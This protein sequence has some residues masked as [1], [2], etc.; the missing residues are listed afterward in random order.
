MVCATTEHSSQHKKWMLSDRRDAGNGCRNT[1][2]LL[3]NVK[4]KFR[5]S[6]Q[7]SGKIYTSRTHLSLPNFYG[8]WHS[9]NYLILH[10]LCSLRSA[11]P[12][13]ACNYGPARLISPHPFKRLLCRLSCRKILINFPLQHAVQQDLAYTS[14]NQYYCRTRVH[15]LTQMSFRQMTHIAVQQ[16]RTAFAAFAVQHNSCCTA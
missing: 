3:Q 1:L 8:L 7:E 11:N 14:L 13:N 15:T 16:T 4:R 10:C 2:Q 6:S 5:R 12:I 9:T